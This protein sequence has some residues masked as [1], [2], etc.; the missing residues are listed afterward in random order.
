[1]TT[2][3]PDLPP[4]RES[5]L[6]ERF[7]RGHGPGG[8]NVNKVA[9][10]VQLWF[11]I[12]GSQLDDEVKQRL[13]SIGGNRVDQEDRLLIRA[14]R[15]RTREQNRR[16]ARERLAALIERASSPPKQRRKRRGQSRKAARAR[17]DAKRRRGALKRDRRRIDD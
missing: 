6:E 10:T 13:R 5:D 4:F 14:R 1:M 11:D 12:G 15:H 16:E 9:T 8:Q 17:I 3:S 7:V 2:T